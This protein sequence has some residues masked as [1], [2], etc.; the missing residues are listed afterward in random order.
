MVP[1][2]C[3]ELQSAEGCGA[4]L[5]QLCCRQ[6]PCLLPVAVDQLSRLV[7][8]YS[9]CTCH[10]LHRLTLLPR[11]RVLV[12]GESVGSPGATTAYVLLFTGSWWTYHAKGPAAAGVMD[13]EQA[14]LV[15]AKMMHYL[16]PSPALQCLSSST[17]GQ[18]STN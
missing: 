11:L 1:V 5:L 18:L 7:S 12:T 3:S 17:Q 10:L 2:C 6:H 13:V 16:R 8:I 15:Y 4:C 14:W 9:G